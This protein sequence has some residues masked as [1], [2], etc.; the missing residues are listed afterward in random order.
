VPRPVRLE[1][2]DCPWPA[3]ASPID[4]E[5][6]RDGAFACAPAGA[7]C[8]PVGCLGATDRGEDAAMAAPPRATDDGEDA[9]ARPTMQAT[10]TP[11]AKTETPAPT[12]PDGAASLT[13]PELGHALL[14][15]WALSKG[16]TPHSQ[17][18]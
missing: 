9:R 14:L 18:H 5:Q 4:N 15:D 12:A 8:A 1:R 10:S 3:C 2:A 6:P 7:T 17:R 11:T 13:R 16:P